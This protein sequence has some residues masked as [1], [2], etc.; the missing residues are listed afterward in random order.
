MEHYR[1]YI[2]FQFLS[3]REKCMAHRQA[4]H[5]SWISLK[6]NSRDLGNFVGKLDILL[7]SWVKYALNGQSSQSRLRS[8]CSCWLEVS[9]SWL[10][11]LWLRVCILEGRCWQ[12]M[13]FSEVLFPPILLLLLFPG[14]G[15][16]PLAPWWLR[17][18]ARQRADALRREL[19]NLR[20]H[21]EA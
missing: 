4:M 9:P 2:P 1:Y 6:K 10:S 14:L 3:M 7:S 5:V 17:N 8:P 20:R 11:A 18:P 19:T 13:G 12:N 15:T 16:C 21:G